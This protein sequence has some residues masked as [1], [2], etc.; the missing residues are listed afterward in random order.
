[1]LILSSSEWFDRCTV[2]IVSTVFSFISQAYLQISVS[3]FEFSIYFNHLIMSRSYFDEDQLKNSPSFID[4]IEAN[5]EKKFRTDGVKFIMNLGARLGLGHITIATGATYFHRFYMRNSFKTSPRYHL[6]ACACLFL[7]GKVEETMKRANVLMHFAKI[8][9]HEI[10]GNDDIF[11]SF[12][13]D[14]KKE[15]FE[16]ECFLLVTLKFDLEL[17]H[18][19]QYLEKYASIFKAPKNIVEEVVQ[20][21]W[22][23]MNDSLCCTTLCIQFQPEIVAVALLSGACRMKALDINDW[24]GKTPGMNKWWEMFV[25]GMTQKDMDDIGTKILG[26]YD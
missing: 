10:H 8:V 4:G 26:M 22:G 25:E 1:M 7:A 14:P 11:N 17:E 12:G 3:S 21:A 20:M 24:N 2:F 6:T 19:Y 23:F 16:V 9:L 15:M 13:D 5:L 18:P